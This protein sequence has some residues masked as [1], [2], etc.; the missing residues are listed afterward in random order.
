MQEHLQDR[1]AHLRFATNPDA[2]SLKLFPQVRDGW[3]LMELFNESV[4]VTHFGRGNNNQVFLLYSWKSGSSPHLSFCC[5]S[6]KGTP[7]RP[8]IWP[9][10]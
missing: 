1:V 10:T 6:C 9:K 7:L 3:G 2:R 4:E 5:F 8:M